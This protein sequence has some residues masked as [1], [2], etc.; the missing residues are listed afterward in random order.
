MLGYLDLLFLAFYL[1]NLLV[2]HIQHFGYLGETLLI[3]LLLG[4]ESSDFFV[5]F[6]NL[7][8]YRTRL[9]DLFYFAYEGFFLLSG[10]RRC[11]DASVQY[12]DTLLEIINS[13]VHGMTQL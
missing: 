1:L 12:F 13:V 8:D 10:K 3:N 6:I 2:N 9:F 5:Y 4:P 11:F 7:L